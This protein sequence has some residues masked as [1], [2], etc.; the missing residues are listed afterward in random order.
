MLAKGKQE[1]VRSYGIPSIIDL[2]AEIPKFVL[3]L[4]KSL[5]STASAVISPSG[6]LPDFGFNKINFR[7]G[8]ITWKNNIVKCYKTFETPFSPDEVKNWAISSISNFV[9][10]LAFFVGFHVHIVSLSWEVT[11]DEGARITYS[12]DFVQREPRIEN[13][14]TEFRKF[15]KYL[16]WIGS[17]QVAVALLE[18]NRAIGELAPSGQLVHL[19]KVLELIE[20][21][22]GGET[23]LIDFLVKKDI[24]RFS[25]KRI[26]K[27]MNNPQYL[28]RHAPDSNN[29]FNRLPYDE[30]NECWVTTRKVLRICLAA[31][32]ENKVAD[33]SKS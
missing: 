21:Q 16:S 12:T 1:P 29:S 33:R 6:V 11:A 30:L 9:D 17:S 14:E 8:S 2:M 24:T 19:Y 3:N 31:L 28:I 23:K 15:G 32:H 20:G 4:S 25:Y 13:G 18:Y 10:L 26:K 7:N 5:D 22:F 27:I